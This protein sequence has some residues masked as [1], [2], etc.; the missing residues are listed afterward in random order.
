MFSTISE[1]FE[2][3]LPVGS[4]ASTMAGLFTSQGDPLL[5][6][7]AHLRRTVQH[8]LVD[9]Q[10]LCDSVDVRLV[11]VCRFA[12][13]IARYIDVALGRERRQKIELLKDEANLSFAHFGALGVRKRSEVN[14]IDDDASAVCMRQA[15]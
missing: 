13:N 10:Q 15:A 1:F 8:P 12:G 11:V 6:T 7:T 5:F 2:S 14:A 9:A 3:R 4:S